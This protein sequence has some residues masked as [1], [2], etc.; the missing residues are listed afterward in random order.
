MMLGHM[1]MIY[2]DLQDYIKFVQILCCKAE[3]STK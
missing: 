3:Q 2:M 1:D